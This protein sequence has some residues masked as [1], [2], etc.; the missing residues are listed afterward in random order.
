MSTTRQTE[1]YHLQKS[2]DRVSELLDRHF[3]VPTLNEV[4]TERTLTWQDG[5][6]VVKFRIGEFC[7]VKVDDSYKFFR[8]CDIANNLAQWEEVNA[9]DL[10]NYYT[11][12]EVNSLL[13]G[14]TGGVTILTK[15][16][17]ESQEIVPNAIYLIVKNGEPEELY[18][19]SMLIGKKGDVGDLGFPYSF[20]IIF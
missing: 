10:S 16:E 13:S 1:G 9:A 12:L 20:P 18:I 6:Y 14:V 5:S 2:G 19:G 11:K 15:E 7:R 17:Y 4:P 8:L 3:I